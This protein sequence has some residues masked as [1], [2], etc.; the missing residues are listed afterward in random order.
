MTDVL[1]VKGLN[2][3]YPHFALHNVTF[4][5]PAGSIM[6]FI[7]RNGAGKSTTLKALLNLVHPDS[8]TVQFFGQDF[9][10]H[11]Q[12]I[13]SAIG[14]AAGNL[15]FYPHQ[16][17][18]KLLA[19]TQQFYPDWDPVACQHYLEV[20]ALDPAKTPQE[21]SA[22]MQVKLNLTL[23]LSHHAKFLLLDEP[24]SGL[25]PV[26][27]A[28]LLE[29]FQHLQQLGIT[30]L[31][32]THITTD[33]ENCADMI[34]YIRQGRIVASEKLTTFLDQSQAA[35]HGD[36]L[37]QIMVNDERQAQAHATTN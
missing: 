14:F 24:T 21:L 10:R 18:R 25:D 20:F 11:E 17:I 27:R 33:L 31:F 8:G 2:K 6:G 26:S 12:E 19:I 22:G 13:K 34:T 37:E 16:R 28:G 15:T 36:H 30:I 7:G 9:R 23:A 3:H 4:T 32:S 5:V 35:G 1:V 29:I